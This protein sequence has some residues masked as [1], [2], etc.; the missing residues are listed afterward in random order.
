[1]ERCV[2]LIRV[3]PE[4]RSRGRASGNDSSRIVGIAESFGGRTEGIWALGGRPHRFVSVASYPD[5]MSARK[6]RIHMEALGL[7]TVEGYPVSEM[8]ECLQAM[9]A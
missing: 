9:A 3:E 7:V 6:A 2:T 8:H 5:E 1:M 4:D